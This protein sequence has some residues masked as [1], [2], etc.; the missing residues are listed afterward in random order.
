M[1]RFRGLALGVLVGVWAVFSEDAAA[2]MPGIPIAVTCTRQT[3][4]DIEGFYRQLRTGGRANFC[5]LK[6]RVVRVEGR[7]LQG[8]VIRHWIG[9]PEGVFAKEAEFTVHKPFLRL[10]LQN[11]ILRSGDSELWFS[12]RAFYLPLPADY[13]KI[14]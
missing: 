3:P 2:S 13:P 12:D 8:V 5:G 11:A 14:P 1:R 10:R 9:D 7:K 4:L 6:I